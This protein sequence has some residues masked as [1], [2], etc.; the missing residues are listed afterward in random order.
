M[1][2]PEQDLFTYNYF[3]V[4]G[5]GNEVSGHLQARSSDEVSRELQSKGITVYSLTNVSLELKSSAAIR[6]VSARDVMIFTRQLA[7]LVKADLPLSESL[8]SLSRD[9][10]K[11]SVARLL[12]DIAADIEG[13]KSLSDAFERRG[14]VF[15]EFYIQLIRAGEAS[16]TLAPVLEQISSYSESFIY[17]KTKVRDCLIYPFFLSTF[18]M[19]LHFLLY[20]KIITGFKEMYSEFEIELPQVTRFFMGEAVPYL[21]NLVL[22]PAFILSVL[23]FFFCLA[24]LASPLGGEALFGRIKLHIPFYGAIFRHTAV[25]FFAKSLGLLLERKFSLPDALRLVSR[26]SPNRILRKL[27][28][29]AAS[30]TEAGRTLSDC[31]DYFNFFPYTVRWLITVAEKRG[32]LPQELKRIAENHEKQ[33]VMAA[34][35]FAQIFEIALILLMAALVAFLIISLFLP[36][37]Q[38]MRGIK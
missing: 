14:N 24:G 25:S 30:D 15:P 35:R 20:S 28:K 12:A 19:G 16:G 8:R 36:L 32:R 2:T 34:E 1:T 37:I 18:I 3:G 27:C 10:R 29:R 23:C 13:G 6:G 17:V 4:D 11:K 31:I 7:E 5:N 38:L 9:L 22:S 21:G 26:S 33:S